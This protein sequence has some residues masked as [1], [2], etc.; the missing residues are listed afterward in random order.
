[1]SIA[2][3]HFS[4]GTRSFSFT[5]HSVSGLGAALDPGAIRAVSDLAQPTSGKWDGMFAVASG[6]PAWTMAAAYLKTPTPVEHAQSL[7]ACGGC[8]A[9]S[10]SPRPIGGPMTETEVDDYTSIL[11]TSWYNDSTAP[12]PLSGKPIILT[13]SFETEAYTWLGEEGY[14]GAFEASFAALSGSEKSL[15]RDMLDEWA[16]NSGIIFIEVP[17]GVGDIQFGKYDFDLDGTTSGFAGFAYF[18]RIDDSGSAITGDVLL[19]TESTVDEDLLLHEIGHALGFKHPFDG[20][21]TADDE[22]D[23]KDYTVMAYDGTPRTDLGPFDLEAVEYVYGSNADDGDHVSS[24]SWNATKLL[25]TQA[26]KAG[27][28]LIRGIHGKDKIA[29]AG[30][31][32][33]IY[34]NAGKDKVDGDA[35]ADAIQGGEGNDTIDG[36]TENDDLEGGD[37]NDKV[38]GGDGDDVILDRAGANKLLGGIGADEITFYSVSDV[39]GGTGT[40]EAVYW[41]DE[42]PKKTLKLKGITDG[43]TISDGARVVG[44]EDFTIATA[45]GKD[46]VTFDNV[47]LGEYLWV[48]EGG[49]DEM[50][51]DWSDKTVFVLSGESGGGLFAATDYDGAEFDTSIFGLDVESIRVTGGSAGDFLGGG[52]GAD[53]FTGGGGGDSF[54][55]DAASQSTGATY[56]RITDFSAAS[57]FFDVFVEVDGVEA[58]VTTGSLSKATFDADLAS[59]IGTSELSAGNAVLFTPSAGNLA[60]KTFLIIDQG[61]GGGYDSGADLVIDVTGGS[62]GGLSASNFF[63]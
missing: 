8:A 42:G 24:W 29:G 51:V 3:S 37:G 36:G 21:P 2:G 13:F 44:I 61:G 15:A 25:L 52:D 18:P 5:N 20:D 6:A 49:I 33:E 57:D 35:G 1:M 55:Y 60:G 54:T 7:C 23:D 27:G 38:S 39:D 4:S 11:R 40:D 46:K 12:P 58:A 32:D 47:G 45:D 43:F 41:Q 59:E 16:D 9:L 31:A 28:D 63:T 22:H 56:D 17:A 14:S 19:D 53:T 62:L 34:A 50:I 30:G 10:P 26:G 48:A